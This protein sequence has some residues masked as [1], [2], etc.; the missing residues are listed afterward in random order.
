MKYLVIDTETGGLDP[1]KNALLEIGMRLY[2]LDGK[3]EIAFHRKI[4][5]EGIRVPIDINA[6]AVNGCN[7]VDGANPETVARELAGWLASMSRRGEVTILGQNLQ[8][9]I[10]FIEEFLRRHGF[11]GWRELYRYR[12]IDTSM[13]ALYLQEA[14]MLPRTV[15]LSLAGLHKHFFG[16]EI[17]HVHTALGDVEATFSV[18]REMLRLTRERISWDGTIAMEG[19]KP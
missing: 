4:M 11:V 15:R 19:K 9:D 12:R 5:W 13:I 18:Y 17:D 3:M 16:T 6:L 2:D 8:F 10:D 7:L 1:R 14:G